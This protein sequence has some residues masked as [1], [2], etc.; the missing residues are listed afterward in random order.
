MKDFQ[1]VLKK[2]FSESDDFMP[3]EVT[4]PPTKFSGRVEDAD[5][6]SDAFSAFSAEHKAIYG[7]F[8][9]ALQVAD[10]NL[11]AMLSHATSFNRSMG[12]RPEPAE[13]APPPQMKK[14][15]RSRVA[16][17]QSDL[18][19][20]NKPTGMPESFNVLEADEMKNTDFIKQTMAAMN[21]ASSQ[22]EKGLNDLIKRTKGKMA[23][24]TASQSGVAASQEE[25]QKKVSDLQADFET[26]S[27]EVNKLAARVQ[28]LEASGRAE[29]H[30]MIQKLS[31]ELEGLAKSLES[32]QAET[33]ALA[34]SLGDVSGRA[35]QNMEEM[36][37]QIDELE[38]YSS[39][40][41]EKYTK[42]HKAYKSIYDR[43]QAQTMIAAPEHVKNY[44]KFDLMEHLS[45]AKSKAKKTAADW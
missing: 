26:A 24:L 14:F 4:S 31:S 36:L 32:K 7:P 11:T 17:L 35:S 27:G 5:T 22:Y 20:M 16:A 33:E 41:H 2:M 44:G 15:D 10:K 29:D 23:E 18:A 34:K 12:Q 9:Q 6:A 42:L 37:A 30:S 43:S 38:K 3:P 25:L 13:F 19:G 40:L 45:R 39:D 1:D 8:K 21:A 28:A